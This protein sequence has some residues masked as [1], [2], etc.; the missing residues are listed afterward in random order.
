MAY[1]SPRSET[2]GVPLGVQK[3]PVDVATYL[4]QI[5]EVAQAF[6]YVKVTW[7]I[8]GGLGSRGVIFPEVLL[9][10]GAFVLNI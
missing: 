8:N 1:D 5:V 2:V 4:L 7:V 6:V 10:S 9:D 3:T